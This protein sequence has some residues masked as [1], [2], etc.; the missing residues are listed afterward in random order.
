[1]ILVISMNGPYPKPK[2]EEQDDTKVKVNNA[3]HKR[4]LTDQTIAHFKSPKNKHKH[5][6]RGKFN[7]GL[8]FQLHVEDLVAQTLQTSN[9]QLIK[10]S[11][12]ILK[13]E[14]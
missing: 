3:T 4:P 6:P 5:H 10:R 9:T 7:P 2:D 8:N 11:Y 1:M 14:A 12:K 13:D